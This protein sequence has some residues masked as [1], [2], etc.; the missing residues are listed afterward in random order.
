M[1]KE[2][3]SK[4]ESEEVNQLPLAAFEGEVYVVDRPEDVAEG[5]RL[6]EGTDIL[7]FDTET[8]PTFRKGGSHKVALLQ[9]ST[10]EKAVLFRLHD[11]GLPQVLIQ[12][13]SNPKVTKVG[14]AIKDDLKALQKL[15]PFKAGG[16]VD[17]QDVVPKYGI[18]CLGLKKMTAIVLGFRISKGQQTSNW[19]ADKLSESQIVY[20]ATDAWAP[21]LIYRSLLNHD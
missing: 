14:V 1:N 15:A 4:I 2:F 8:K 7:G 18:D 20:A 3:P 17:L 11:T 16:F 5:V 21:N 6:L 12:L 9:L 13:L 10:R 19:E